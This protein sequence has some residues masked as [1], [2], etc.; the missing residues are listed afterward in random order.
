MTWV[1]VAIAVVLD[2]AAGLI[3]GVIPEAWLARYRSAMLG[4][5]TGALLAAAALDLVPAALDAIGV[6]ALGWVGGS[7]VA[8]AMVERIAGKIAVPYAVLGADA[9]HNF[10]DG[11]AIAAAF[12]T[13]TRLGTVTAVAVIVHE[14][15]E[16]LADYAILRE[17]R[18]GKVRSLIAL[19]GV[20]LTAGIGAAL[21]LVGASFGASTGPMLGVAGATFVYIAAVDI[22][23]D[24]VRRGM[25]PGA[26]IGFVLGA[27]AIALV[28]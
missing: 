20:Q 26:I 8:L 13:S 5:A 9:L 23:P 11:V 4:F 1:W 24:L 17:A 14:L 6:A 3:G 12:A 21:L 7:V 18:L 27:M 15:P 2:G 16:E 10:G 28:S 19:A 22:L 25:G